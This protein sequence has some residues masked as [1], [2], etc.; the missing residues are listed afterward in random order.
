MAVRLGVRGDAVPCFADEA[1]RMGKGPGLTVVLAAGAAI[2]EDE[3]DEDQGAEGGGQ[4]GCVDFW[5][6]ACGGRATAGA[7]TCRGLYGLG[8]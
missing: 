7:A 1:W 5:K 3:R 6:G 4:G 8:V 2:E